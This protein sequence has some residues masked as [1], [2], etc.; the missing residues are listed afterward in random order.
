MQLPFGKRVMISGFYVYKHARV[1]S[2]KEMKALRSA[3]YIPDAAAKHLGRASLPVITIGTVTDSWKIEFCVGMNMYEAIDEIPVA[4]DGEGKYTYYGSGYQILGNLINGWFAYTST[5]GD[6]EYQAD[7]IKA[8]QRYIE[9][10]SKK[11][12]EPLDK[13]EAEKVLDKC[14]ASE[15]GASAL[16][17]MK[18][19]AEKEDTNGK[20]K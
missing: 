6:A 13:Q 15:R 19:E 2:K 5:V 7:V 1:L 9:R 17:K 10:A 12:S 14:E 11:N 16:R 8:M 3:S 18:T 20:D 4:M